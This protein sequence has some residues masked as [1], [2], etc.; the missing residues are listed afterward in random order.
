MRIFLIFLMC[1]LVTG[2]K[3]D[4][5]L[6]FA[7]AN[8]GLTIKFKRKIMG[9]TVPFEIKCLSGVTVRPK[10][11][12]KPVWNMQRQSKL[13]YTGSEIVYGQP[14]KGYS[15]YLE[16]LRPGTV[17]TFSVYGS[18]ASGTAEYRFTSNTIQ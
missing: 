2:C 15:H 16:P 10:N 17:Y 8:G 6:L 4:L 14:V 3:Y 18:G 1:F 13:C 9:I 7:Q 12:E 11:S 5:K